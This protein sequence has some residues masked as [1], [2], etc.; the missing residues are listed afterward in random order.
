MKTSQFDYNLPKKL[1][2]QKPISPRDNSKLMVLDR[3]KEKIFHSHFFDLDKFL[4]KGDV[5]VFNNTK[6]IPA[7]IFGKKETGGKIEILLL[8]PERKDFQW[9]SKWRVL[10]KPGIKK[11]ME[12]FFGKNL[13]AKVLSENGYERII[14]F[15]KKGKELE[16]LIF[17]LGKMPIPPYI[18]NSKEIDLR[19][20]YQTIFSSIIGSVAAPTAG[21]HF[22]TRLLKKLK[23][24]GVV[25]EYITLHIGLG[26]FQ[27]VSE[28]DI[29]KHKIHS[30]Y[31]EIQ[32]ETAKRLNKAKRE[33]R[34]IIAVGTT[35]IRTLEYFTEKNVLKSGRKM[36]DL[37]IYPPFDF[38]FT[39]G[40]ITNF[41]L[42]KST[43]LMLVSAFA[44]REFI[45]KS[46]AEAIKKNYRFYSFGDGMLIL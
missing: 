22:T 30:E 7:R 46:Y 21:F 9:I 26:T 10:S 34:R 8:K 18:K 43:L 44:T 6:V 29:E 27:P 31:G 17:Q 40:L 39:D 13:K 24:K 2:A 28:E 25:I 12:I 45:L 33:G 5:L 38:K 37:F 16:K 42:P 14:E 35:S 3:K 15:N 20:K 1:I 32:K 19:K 4:Q 41:H 23:K 36:I 11:N